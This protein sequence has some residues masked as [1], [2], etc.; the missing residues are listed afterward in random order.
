MS[1]QSGQASSTNTEVTDSRD[2][3]TDAQLAFAKLLGRLLAQ[4]WHEELRSK[5]MTDRSEM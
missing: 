2:P 5:E 4:H 1:E 3:L